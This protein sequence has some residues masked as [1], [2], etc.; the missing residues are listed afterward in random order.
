MCEERKKERRCVG[1]NLS[2]NK[3]KINNQQLI[4]AQKKKV[5]ISYN[6]QHSL[7]YNPNRQPNIQIT[8]YCIRLN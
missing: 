1:S 2:T 5:L 6:E 3:K 8:L 4:L 7:I